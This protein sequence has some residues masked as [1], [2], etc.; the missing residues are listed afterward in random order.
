MFQL[1][2]KRQR[3]QCWRVAREN[4]ARPSK[5]SDQSVGQVREVLDNLVWRAGAE[6]FSPRPLWAVVRRRRLTPRNRSESTCYHADRRPICTLNNTAKRRNAK[7]TA[8]NRLGICYS[9]ARNVDPSELRHVNTLQCR[10]ASNHCAEQQAGASVKFSPHRKTEFSRAF[11]SHTIRA[12][13]RRLA[14]VQIERLDWQ[15]FI[16]RYDRDFTLF[17]LDPPYWGHEAAYG[18]GVFARED[19]GRM[20]DVLRGAQGPLHSVAE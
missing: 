13:H 2:S 20:A 3:L 11:V 1:W 19:F 12:A 18:K 7:S 17:Y 9:T 16:R 8:V 5:T 6:V 15:E 14:G 10:S 4:C